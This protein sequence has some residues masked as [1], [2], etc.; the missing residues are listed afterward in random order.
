MKPWIFLFCQVLLLQTTVAQ[1]LDCNFKSPVITIDFGDDRNP[2]DFALTQL[3]DH[4]RRVDHVC[5]NDGEFAFS[6][7]TSNCYFGNWHNI[8]KDHTPGSNRGRMMIVNASYKPTTFFSVTLTALKPNTTYEFGAWFVNVCPGREGCEPTPPIIRVSAFADG[9]FLSSFNT[10]AINPAATVN[11]Q[12]YTGMFST[13]AAFSAITVAMDDVTSGGCG[14]DFALDD[15]EIRECRKIP[16]VQPVTP[17]KEPVIITKKKEQSQPLLPAPQP[18]PVKPRIATK[19]IAVIS[20]DKAIKEKTD[21]KPSVKAMYSPVP[22][23]DVISKRANPVIKRIETP[24]SEI[25]I[26]LYDNG[27]ID[28]DTVTI[29]HNNKMI[30]AQAGISTKPV[31]VTIT[32]NEKEP[33]HELVMVAD[34][35][36]SIPPNT[37]LMI[38]TTQ[39]QRHEIFISSTEQKNAKI[40]IDLKKE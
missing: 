38:V 20:N 23:P 2:Q 33:H 27:E 39:Y 40:I 8:T 9:K 3:K 17:K 1:T 32:V 16:P 19:E 28:G 7:Y 29:Y 6:S 31:K 11:W 36:G 18:E 14:N 13:P 35:L 4:Y 30:V 34:N 26:E 25:T 15:I 37:S 5:P 21:S 10:G 24:A 22:V 12:R